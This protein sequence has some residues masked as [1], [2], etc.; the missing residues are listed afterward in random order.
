MGERSG[1][2]HIVIGRVE[3]IESRANSTVLA[4]LARAKQNGSLTVAWVSGATVTGDGFDVLWSDVDITD[5]DGLRR[6]FEVLVQSS[7]SGER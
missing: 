3:A 5:A 6:L 2:H 7:G 4:L 1:E